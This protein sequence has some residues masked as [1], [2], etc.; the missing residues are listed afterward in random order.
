MYQQH[1]VQNQ[2][3][4][5]QNYNIPNAQ[6][7]QQIQMNNQLLYQKQLAQKQAMQRNQAQMQNIQKAHQAQNIQNNPNAQKIQQNQNMQNIYKMQQAQRNQ[8]IQNVQMLHNT[9]IPQNVNGQ[10]QK[11]RDGNK[12]FNTGQIQKNMMNPQGAK[13]MPTNQNIPQQMNT[14]QARA[15]KPQANPQFNNIASSHL[16]LSPTNNLEPIQAN[17]PGHIQIQQQQQQRQHHHHQNQNYNQQQKKEAQIQ[18]QNQPVM[19]NLKNTAYM[20]MPQN[21]KFQ[22]Q[23]NQP[24]M[25]NLKNTAFLNNQQNPKVQNQQNQPIMENLKNTAFLTNPQNP[26]AQN[27]Q[28]LR[29]QNPTKKSATLMTINSLANIE[30]KEYPQVEVSK[31]Q[32]YNISGYAANSYNGKIKSYNEDKYTAILPKEGEN[33]ING[34]PTKS[35]VSY[36]GLFDGHGGDKCSIFLKNKMHD[37]LLKSKSFPSDPILSI[38]EAFKNAEMQFYKEAVQN[39]KMV[40]RSGSCAVISLIIDNTLY[41]INLGDSRALYSRD[42]GKEFYQITRDHKPNDEIEQKRITS[43]GGKVY[44]ANKTVV[45][46]VEVTLKESDF[47]KGFTFPYRLSPSGLAVSFFLLFNNLGS[48]NYWGLL[49]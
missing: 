10:Q 44:Y 43:C 5:Y 37:L 19:E 36:F 35:F 1:P 25:E 41:S 39:G 27:Q 26:K 32:F 4:V 24:V 11:L 16:D 17:L 38:K 29:A 48:K 40:D 18:P 8:N 22:N 13:N 23:Q 34:T 6:N 46:G 30:Y 33:V 47:G 14:Y 49:F 15:L 42:S 7:P 2:N 28:N 45:N 9:Q 20:A 12:R 21:Q 3:V 31:K